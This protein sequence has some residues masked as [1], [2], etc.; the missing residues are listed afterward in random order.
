MIFKGAG[1]A[2]VTPFENGE[3]NFKK[4][5]ELIDKQIENGIDAI[6]T[7]GTTGEGSALS[8]V[9]HKQVMEYC[10]K[11][12]AGRVPVIA[13]TGSNDTEYGLQLSQ[14]A[15]KI[16][17]DGLMM[18]TPYY[19]KT[20]QRGLIN[21]FTYIADRVNRPI[22]LYNV[23]SRTAMTIEVET[24]V[25]LSKHKNIVAMKDATGDIGY[26]A[27]LL[28]RVD[29]N[30]NVYS[31]NDNMILPILSLG[32]IGVISVI[33]NIMPREVHELVDEF[34]KGNIE[35]AKKIQLDMISLI[36]ALFVEINPIPVKTA[37]NLMGLDVGPVRKPLYE[38]EEKNVEFLK[39]E[40]KKR[41]LVMEE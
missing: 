36:N 25:E 27:E 28:S 7:C 11:K 31:G 6:I 12:V 41:W 29:E 24:A 37:L 40:L 10:V 16:G 9:E 35:K 14:A 33:S 5:G 22:I 18:V 20:T 19:N 30:F 3:V 15:C 13:G 8:D 39:E 26:A 4:Y 1:T 23:P 2:L 38:M 21:H 34:L 17:V 32:G